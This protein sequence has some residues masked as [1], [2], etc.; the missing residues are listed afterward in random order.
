VEA[1]NNIA[2]GEYL[3]LDSEDVVALH[4]EVLGLIEVFRT[5]VDNAASTG[6]FRA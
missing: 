5:Q 2:H 6:A 4:S 3:K 1:R